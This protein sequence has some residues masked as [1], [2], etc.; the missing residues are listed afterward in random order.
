M[1]NQKTVCFD[2][3]GVLAHYDGWNNGKIGRPLP[4]GIGLAQLLTKLGY[5]IVICTCRTHPEHG[6]QEQQINAVTSWLESNQ[7]PY[8]D[9]DLLGKPIADIYLDDRGL[10]FDPQY[11]IFPTYAG[12]M[13]D[14]ITEILEGQ[15][16]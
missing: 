5:K 9:L 7:V 6:T 3:D 1:S 16:Q 14:R 2:F 13:A 15:T 10:R 11:G 12:F 8:D 4:G